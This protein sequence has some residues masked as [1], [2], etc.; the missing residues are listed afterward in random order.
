MAR[1]VIFNKVYVKGKDKTLRLA[2]RQYSSEGD[3]DLKRILVNRLIAEGYIDG[4]KKVGA[5]C[6][7]SRAFVLNDGTS[8]EEEHLS[9]RCD[10]DFGEPLSYQD[11]FKYYDCFCR[12]AWNRA[13]DFNYALD[14]TDGCIEGEWDSWHEEFV[15]T[16]NTVY[17]WNWRGGFYNEET[18]D[19]DR[20]DDFTEIDGEFYD[21]VNYSQH[22]DCYY[23]LDKSTWC[24]EMED[25]L[26]DDEYE[27][28]LEEWK[29]Y[30][31]KW[32]EY[33]EKLVEET[34]PVHV[35]NDGKG[36]YEYMSVE[37]KYA[38]EYFYFMDGEYYSEVSE[39]GT[40]YKS[41]L[42]EAV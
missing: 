5:G 32:D 25:Y 1:C 8:L 39:D 30:N 35:W 17:V 31:W 19:A 2:E 18:C 4:Y 9:I 13:G 42:C 28:I 40:P 36:M 22:Y 34:V 33:N 10:L 15:R 20:M 12:I 6:H 37:K 7:D 26:P 23:P 27:E 24:E 3:D 21:E 29:S 16:T 14:T 38:M 11:S 41:V